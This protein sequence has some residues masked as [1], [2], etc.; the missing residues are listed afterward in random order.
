MTLWTQSL[1]QYMDTTVPMLYQY[2]DTTVPIKRVV[3]GLNEL[4][5]IKLV[6]VLAYSRCRV[7]NSFRYCDHHWVSSA[8]SVLCLEMSAHA[9]PWYMNFRSSG[10]VGSPQRCESATTWLRQ[11][12]EGCKTEGQCLLPVWSPSVYFSP[13]V[14]F[15]CSRSSMSDQRCLSKCIHAGCIFSN[16][17]IFVPESFSWQT[18]TWPS[19]TSWQLLR[20]AS[21]V[22]F[23]ILGQDAGWSLL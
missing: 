2:M 14:V 22:G 5:C 12:N 15:Y 16:S 18:P 20:A 19:L 4:R 23:G 17:G 6:A 9:G 11:G 8:P 3:V 10:R 7:R 13:P 1:Y 21:N